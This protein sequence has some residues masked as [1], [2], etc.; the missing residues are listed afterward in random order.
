[1]AV[2]IFYKV[3]LIIIMLALKIKNRH[4]NIDLVDT[5]LLELGNDG[6]DKCDSGFTSFGCSG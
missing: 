1:M 4:L 6:L 5:S 3:L 2:Y